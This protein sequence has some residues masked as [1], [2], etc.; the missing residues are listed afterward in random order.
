MSA[1]IHDKVGDIYNFRILRMR[2]FP[3]F[4]YDTLKGCREDKRAWVRN[5]CE[6]MEIHGASLEVARDVVKRFNEK[7]NGNL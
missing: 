2:G 3:C 4:Q 6:V 7:I 1:R 5:L